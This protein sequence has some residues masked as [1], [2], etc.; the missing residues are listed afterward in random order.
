MS[1]AVDT[2]ARLV[3]KK[4]RTVN[5]VYYKDVLPLGAKPWRKE[6]SVKSTVSVKA[7]FVSSGHIKYGLPVDQQADA[8]GVPT[9]E[10]K[11]YVAAQ[12]LTVDPSVKCELHDGNNHWKVV[13]MVPL[14]PGA[15][16]ILYTLQVRR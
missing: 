9:E 12:G 7:V 4:G 14:N 1:S 16:K 5:L 13:S 15:E 10:Q 2:A 11:V 3:A 8:D 6:S